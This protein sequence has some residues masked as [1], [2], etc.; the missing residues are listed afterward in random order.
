MEDNLLT[1]VFLFNWPPPKFLFTFKGYLGRSASWVLNL[2]RTSTSF[3]ASDGSY[4]L[5]CEFVPNQWGFFADIPFFIFAC[6]KK[7]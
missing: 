6:R 5:K 4:D 1:T 7:A 2:K 3:N